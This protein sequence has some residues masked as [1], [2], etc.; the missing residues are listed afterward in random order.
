MPHEVYGFTGG[1]KDGDSELFCKFLMYL[2][3]SAKREK[4]FFF[5]KM[6]SGPIN[7]TK[8][9]EKMGR[10]SALEAMKYS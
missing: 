6:A 7:A 1:E 10:H 9:P 5:N 4:C 2:I 3:K 8:M